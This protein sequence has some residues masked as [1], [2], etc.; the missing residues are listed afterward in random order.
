MP[1]CA[2]EKSHC[3]DEAVTIVEEA[4]YDDNHEINTQCRCLPACT[5]M[6]FP[7]ENSVSRVKKSDM[8]SL[9]PTVFG[10]KNKFCFD[11]CL[12]LSA[13]R[14]KATLAE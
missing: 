1:I 5:D 7:H 13:H 9:P 11:N 3:V 8:L 12:I 6:E 4:A 14:G 10:K 2:P